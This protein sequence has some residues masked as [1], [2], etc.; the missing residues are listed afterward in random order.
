MHVGV[1]TWVCAHMHS[2]L[3]HVC[4][5]MLESIQA[6]MHV[7]CVNI[8]VFV[9]RVCVYQMSMCVCVCIS[10][11]LCGG[12]CTVSVCMCVRGMVVYCASVCVLACM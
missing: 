3:M 5:F 8:Q 9:C 11:C 7:L 1:C 2:Y 6:S 4:E 12:S 10:A